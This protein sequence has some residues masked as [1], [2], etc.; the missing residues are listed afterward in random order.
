[1]VSQV[2][3]INRALEKIGCKPITNITDNTEEARSA[4]RV[5]EQVRKDMLCEGNWTFAIK[6]ENLNTVTDTIDWER[7]SMD[8]IFQLPSDFVKM[9]GVSDRRAIW[10]IEG[11]KL[12]TDYDEI[13]IKY[14]Y[15]LTD[16]IKFSS[17]FIEA[18]TDKLAAEMA[19]GLTSNPEV[20]SYYRERYDNVSLPKALSTDSIGSGTPLGI[21]DGNWVE[22]KFGQISDTRRGQNYA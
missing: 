7:D 16:V 1:M 20:A 12:I 22:S 14:I 3:I 17:L 19:F 6:R 10:T 13:G 4:N 11:D 9:V 8:Y 5:W 15:D 21:D 2:S 18:M